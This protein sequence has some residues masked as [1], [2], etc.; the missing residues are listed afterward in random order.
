MSQYFFIELTP[1]FRASQLSPEDDSISRD[2]R[3]AK[4]ELK[5]SKRKDYYKILGVDKNASEDDIKK[6]YRKL[7]LKWHPGTIFIELKILPPKKNWTNS[8]Y[9]LQLSFTPKF[10]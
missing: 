2:L 7:A 8:H 5:K 1:Y 6:A 4:I 10:F 9:F 3:Q